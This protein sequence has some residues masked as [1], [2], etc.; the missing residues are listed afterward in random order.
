MVVPRAMVGENSMGG[1]VG[2]TPEKLNVRFVLPP[3]VIL[4]VTEIV[5]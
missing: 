4:V 1:G 3:V 5:G 2:S